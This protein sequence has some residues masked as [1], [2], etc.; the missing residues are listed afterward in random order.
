MP[1]DA[2]ISIRAGSVRRQMAANSSKAY[3]FPK[4]E[5]DGD[6]LL[7]FDILARIGSGYAVLKPGVDKKQYRVVLGD[8]MSC[9]VQVRPSDPGSPV[10]TEEPKTSVDTSDSKAY[11]DKTGLLAFMQGVLQVTVKEKPTDPYTFMAKHFLSGYDALD[12]ALAAQP[13]DATEASCEEAEADAKAGAPAEEEAPAEEAPGGGGSPEEEAPPLVDAILAEAILEEAKDAPAEEDEG[14]P[15]LPEVEDMSPEVLAEEAKA[16]VAEEE[17]PVDEA[18]AAAAQD[19]EAEAKEAPAEEAPAEEAPA[20]EAPLRPVAEEA[21]QA[22]EALAEGEDADEE[23]EEEGEEGED[24]GAKAEEQAE[25]GAAAEGE[26][27]TATSSCITFVGQRV[28]W[29]L[30]LGGGKRTGTWE[31]PHFSLRRGALEGVMR[32]RS[33]GAEGCELTVC[34][35]GKRPESAKALLF[36]SKNWNAKKLMVEWKGEELRK[37]FKVALA[38]RA[39]VLCGLVYDDRAARRVV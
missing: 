20:E 24:E 26:Q 2:I 33:L 9:E 10:A 22:E 5:P 7:K 18:P 29:Q 1:D 37:R 19:E 36:V 8:A 4:P 39:A 30:V 28:N 27:A 21:L 12:C 15:D 32:L 11:M 23:D 38:G 34:L 16:A 14:P 31:S 17:A 35:T 6:N 3:K 13:P 25:E